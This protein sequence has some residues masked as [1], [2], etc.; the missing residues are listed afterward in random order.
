MNKAPENWR[1]GGL[2]PQVFGVDARAVF[3][4]QQHMAQDIFGAGPHLLA[5]TGFIAQ[6]KI[7]TRAK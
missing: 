5:G 7:P 4:Q 3:P 6:Q 2:T 1:D